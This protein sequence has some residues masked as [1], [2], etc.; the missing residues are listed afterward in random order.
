MTSTPWHLRFW[1]QWIAANSLA[2]LLGLGGV[3]LVALGVSLSLLAAGAL[4]G[5][6]HG[7]VLIWLLSSA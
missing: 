6:V 2:E 7:L 3:A 4:V 1:R 5:A